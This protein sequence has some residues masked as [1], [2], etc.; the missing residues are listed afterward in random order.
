[1]PLSA[2]PSDLRHNAIIFRAYSSSMLARADDQFQPLRPPQERTRV[3]G[4]ELFAGRL[5]T[6]H[7]LHEWLYTGIFFA[8]EVVG[9]YRLARLILHVCTHRTIGP[10]GPQRS[11]PASW[12]LQGY[13][14][15]FRPVLS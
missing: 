5:R 9:D 15:P 12:F 11:R 4:F 6:L 1:M 14:I 10:Q 13:F 7:A 3:E 8:P 2:E